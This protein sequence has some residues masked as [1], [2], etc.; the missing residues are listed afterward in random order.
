MACKQARS[1]LTEK[2]NFEEQVI[3]A[4]KATKKRSISACLPAVGLLP[5]ANTGSGQIQIGGIT[6]S[7]SEIK[8]FYKLRQTFARINFASIKGQQWKNKQQRFHA[9]GA[10]Q[11]DI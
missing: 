6:I 2:T 5:V 11:S 9:P 1:A 7:R 4:L 8:A 10:R 3:I